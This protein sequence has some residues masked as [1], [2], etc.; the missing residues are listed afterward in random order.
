M[1]RYFGMDQSEQGI[2][3]SI[4]QVCLPLFTIGGFLLTSLK[5]PQYGVIAGLISQIFWLYA[6]YRAWRKADQLGIFANTVLSTF[7]FIYGVINY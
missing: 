7:I 3:N 1:V 6:S 5:L 4:V 2:W